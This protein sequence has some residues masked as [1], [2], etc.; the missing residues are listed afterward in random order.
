MRAPNIIATKC[1]NPSNGEIDKF[2][3]TEE[4]LNFL[5]LVIETISGSVFKKDL[6]NNEQH[7]KEC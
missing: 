4:S 6:E 5:L 3:I 1:I 2:T 7:K